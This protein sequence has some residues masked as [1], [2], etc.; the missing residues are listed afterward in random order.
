[1]TTITKNRN[2]ERADDKIDFK[3]AIK[4]WSSVPATVDG[5]LG[6]YGLQTV[7]PAQ[8]IHGSM[9]FVRKLESR[10]VPSEGML[11]Y[12]ADI[13]AGIGRVTFNFLSKIS[14]KIDLVEPVKQ[15]VK[16][17]QT[18]LSELTKYGK[19][20]EFYTQ[21][22]QDWVP[23]EGKYWLIWCQWCLCHLPDDQL[24]KFLRGCVRGLQ[25]NGTIVVKENNTVGEN[26]F[27]CKD[28]SV[29]RSDKK[30]RSIFESANLE[31]IATERQKGFPDE[32]YPVR[33][34]ALKPRAA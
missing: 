32:L 21:A 10:M 5:V 23:E 2:I 29:T 11:R 15:F 18:E 20:G 33:L 14:D 22:M 8:D 30:F 9:Q 25:Q 16:Q 7:V 13:G 12:S 4:Y 1:M 6:G 26:E 19:I 28:S 17:A 3:K 31:L 24:V 27:H 34:Y